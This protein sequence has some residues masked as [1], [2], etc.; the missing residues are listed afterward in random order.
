MEIVDVVDWK[1]EEKNSQFGEDNGPGWAGPGPFL[2]Q[3]KR[4]RFGLAQPSN[5][6]ELG[7]SKTSF[8][9]A[10][11]ASDWPTDFKI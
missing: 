4:A 5:W 11:R 10:R 6:A 8:R 7:N 1:S 9:P 3:T 2:A